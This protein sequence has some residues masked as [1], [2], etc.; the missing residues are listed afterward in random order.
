MIFCGCCSKEE[1]EAE[2]KA[3]TDLSKAPQKK[4]SLREEEEKEDGVMEQKEDEKI[5][6]VE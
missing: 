2:K 3:E 1:Q 4:P 5:E 6:D